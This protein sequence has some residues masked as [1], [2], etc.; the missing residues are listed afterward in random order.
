MRKGF[1]KERFEW[2]LRVEMYYASYPK[3]LLKEYCNLLLTPNYFLLAQD[4]EIFDVF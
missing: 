1:S 3:T 2:V 4:S